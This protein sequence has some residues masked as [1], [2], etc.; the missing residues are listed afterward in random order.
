MKKLPHPFDTLHKKD[1]HY[2]EV[3]SGHTV[4]Q[5]G[6]KTTAI[7]YLQKGSVTMSRWAANGDEIIIHTAK[8]GEN[9]AEAALFSDKYHCYAQ[10]R[11][12][13]IL[14]GISKPVILNMFIKEP[15]FA[16]SLSAKFAQQ[17]QFL[18]HQKELLA[19]RSAPERVY[20]AMCEGMLT[21]DIKTFASSI[22]LTHETVYRALA[23]LVKEKSL[24]KTYRG[25]YE[26]NYL[27]D[28]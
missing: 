9:F 22:G 19:I 21:T 1:L 24:V 15:K 27:K 5:Q 20:A 28:R 17:V 14:W 13:C 26:I 25:L 2:L 12:P 4:F 23:K 16:L 6:E 11:T 18:R 7:Y 10:T 8:D 3:E